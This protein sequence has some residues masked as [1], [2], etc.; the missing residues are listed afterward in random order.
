MKNNLQSRRQKLLSELERINRQIGWTQ[1]DLV[2]I[3]SRIA[4]IQP[5][6][7]KAA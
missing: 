2:R 7:A 3:E 4:A 1:K 6:Q 5:A